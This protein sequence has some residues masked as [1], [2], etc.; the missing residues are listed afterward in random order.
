MKLVMLSEGCYINDLNMSDLIFKKL[1]RAIAG[2]VKRNV[3]ASIAIP[4]PA[5]LRSAYLTKGHLE[6]I[7]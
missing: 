2:L 6:V 5:F 7:L 1:N 3:Q 4:G